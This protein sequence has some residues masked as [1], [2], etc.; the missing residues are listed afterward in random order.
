[1]MKIKM[2]PENILMIQPLM[3]VWNRLH[4]VYDRPLE[5]ASS[6]CSSIK[7]IG[8][9]LANGIKNRLVELAFVIATL[10]VGLYCLLTFPFR[11]YKAELLE[12]RSIELDLARIKKPVIGS[13]EL[14]RYFNKHKTFFDR[15]S[16]RQKGKI[17]RQ[18]TAQCAR[19]QAVFAPVARQFVD[20]L[21]EAADRGKRKLV[22]MARDGL[23]FYEVAQ[24]LMKQEEYQKKYP[25]LAKEGALVYGYFSR[26]L[27]F[28]SLSKPELFQQYFAENLGVK[29]LENCIFA[30]I[31]FSGRMVDPI[32]KLLPENDIV[33]EFLVATSDK[34][35]G[36]LAT[37]DQPLPYFESEKQNLGMRWMEETH[38]GTLASGTELALDGEKNRVYVVHDSKGVQS[39]KYPGKVRTEAKFSLPYL[40]RKF[41][42]KAVVHSAADLPLQTEKERA[43]T[44]KIFSETIRQI[45]N[46]ELLIPVGWDQ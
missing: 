36:F 35:N 18:V 5:P 26:E 10:F 6:P 42:L 7:K 15:Q 12:R 31:G 9:F 22:F 14:F 41:C 40:I 13:E 25:F 3:T 23:P 28:K 17:I 19:S 46:G 30:D 44:K 29:P 20:H 21:L 39:E 38:H 8:F 37:P 43:E 2:A 32:R 33:F 24:K 45:K 11:F 4:S 1:M 27:V 34:A 16:G